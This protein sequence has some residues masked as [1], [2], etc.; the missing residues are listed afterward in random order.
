MKELIAETLTRSQFQN[1]PL[2]PHS[3]HIFSIPPIMPISEAPSPHPQKGYTM[4]HFHYFHPC[5]K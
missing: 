1:N 2:F 5:T 4:I 3:K